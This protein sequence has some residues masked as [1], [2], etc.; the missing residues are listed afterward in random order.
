MQVSFNP[1]RYMVNNRYQ[2]NVNKQTPSFGA[3]IYSSMDDLMQAINKIAS[4]TDLMKRGNL[5]DDIAIKIKNTLCQKPQ[6]IE[7]KLVNV[8]IPNSNET[9][10][11]TEL[12][13]L[14]MRY[15]P[16]GDEKVVRNYLGDLIKLESYANH[17]KNK[18]I[19]EL[20]NAK[21]HSDTIEFL[22]TRIFGYARKRG[23]KYGYRISELEANGQID[24]LGGWSP[25]KSIDA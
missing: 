7:I 5:L 23:N 22:N 1:A 24:R 11:I 16:Q 12:S 9:K 18:N 15:I 20:L 25:K 14:L 21:G 4:E 2:T 19:V 6:N 13:N 17:Q 3:G 8:A 10:T